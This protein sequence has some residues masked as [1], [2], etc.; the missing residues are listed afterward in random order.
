MS[1]R[2]DPFSNGVRRLNRH[3][4]IY[5]QALD[6]SCRRR[7]GVSMSVFRFL[8]LGLNAL[9]L[10]I[11]WSLVDMGGDPTLGLIIV[12][13]IFGG[14]EIVETYLAESGFEDIRLAVRRSEADDDD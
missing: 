10:V 7:L 4:V 13:L 12:F 14:A 8:K 6:Y 11:A 1:H 2:H 9:G 5:N 3:L